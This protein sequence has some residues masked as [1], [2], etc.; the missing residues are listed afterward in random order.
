MFVKM[1]LS[2]VNACICRFDGSVYSVLDSDFWSASASNAADRVAL[3]RESVCGAGQL[4]GKN[5]TDFTILLD[6]D[7]GMYTSWHL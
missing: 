5:F 6:L 7:F 4:C 1:V 2:S 3:S